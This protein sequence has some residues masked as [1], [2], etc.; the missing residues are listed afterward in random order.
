MLINFVALFWNTFLS[1]RANSCPD[2]EG[3]GAV[4]GTV[5]GLGEDTPEYGIIK[6]TWE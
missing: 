6:K 3:V 4:V 1:W 2:V 5:V